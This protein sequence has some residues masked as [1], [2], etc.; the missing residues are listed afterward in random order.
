M[1]FFPF[2]CVAATYLGL[3][4]PA[5][6]N[7]RCLQAYSV[8]WYVVLFRRGTFIYSFYLLFI[9]PQS[10]SYIFTINGRVIDEVECIS[11]VIIM[12]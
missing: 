3:S 6:K 4:L 8:G 10:Q 1:F 7:N 11:V 12:A 9:L 2:A 5:P